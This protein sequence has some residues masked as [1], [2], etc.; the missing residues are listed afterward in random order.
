MGPPA[1]AE[2][3]GAGILGHGRIRTVA[4]AAQVSETT[5]RRRPDRDRD[6][7]RNPRSAALRAEGG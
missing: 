3:A 7:A 6:P 5:V 4:Q 2:E 1:A